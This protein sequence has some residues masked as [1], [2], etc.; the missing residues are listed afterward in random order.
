M[1]FLVTSYNNSFHILQNSIHPSRYL[2]MCVTID[3]CSPATGK[4]SIIFILTFDQFILKT[5]ITRPAFT[6]WNNIIIVVSFHNILKNIVQNMFSN[7]SRKVRRKISHQN[8]VFY[9]REIHGTVLKQPIRLEY[10][11]KQKRRGAL[12]E[13][14]LLTEESHRRGR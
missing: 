2:L 1:R 12:A 9:Q 11:I 3:S 5:R 13:R 14:K 6:V 4:K 8:C 10:L 7:I